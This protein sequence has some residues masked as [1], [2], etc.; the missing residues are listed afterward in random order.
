[1]IAVILGDNLTV[2][3]DYVFFVYGLAFIV[4]A[5]V[6]RMPA[7]GPRLPSWPW[8]TAFAV[9]HGVNE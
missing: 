7:R 5:L 3:L 6:S 4:L 9:T 2:G 1:M 8:L